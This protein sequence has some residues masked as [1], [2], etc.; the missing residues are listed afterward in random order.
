MKRYLLN[1]MYVPAAIPDVTT[2]ADLVSYLNEVLGCDIPDLSGA[3]LVIGAH[4]V[5]FTLEEIF[6]TFDL[7]TSAISNT[8]N[9]LVKRGFLKSGNFAAFD[10]TSR[11]YYSITKSGYDMANSFFLGTLPGK[12]KY[13]RKENAVSHIYS[14]GMNFFHALMLHIPFYYRKEVILN[15]SLS[16][17]F[18]RSSKG[19]LQADCVITFKS[20]APEVGQLEHTFYVEEDLGFERDSVLHEKLRRYQSLGIM[21]RAGDGILFSFRYKDVSA[22]APS[23]QGFGLYSKKGALYILDLMHNGHVLDA[24]ELTD[25][26]S[27]DD[28]PYLYDFLTMCGAY[29]DGRI[30]KK[31]PAV[32]EEFLQDFIS[33]LSYHRNEYAIRDMNRRQCRLYRSRLSRFVSLYFTWAGENRVLSEMNAYLSGFSVYFAPTCLFSSYLRFLLPAESGLLSSLS[34][35]LLSYYADLGDYMLLSPPLLLDDGHTL[36]FRNCFPYLCGETYSG[37]VCVE[38]LNT[39]LC[40]WIRVL[41][42]LKLYKGDVPFHILC[43]FDT[44]EQVNEFYGYLLCYYGETAIFLDKSLILCTMSYELGREKRFFTMPDP[45]GK[46]AR[47]RFYHSA[48]ALYADL[49]PD[50]PL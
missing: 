18:N 8:I 25:T 17:S 11:K 34:A 7:T 28:A 12:Y 43:V 13:G 4:V 41:Y 15:G 16:S 10:G 24:R 37:F 31:A 29:K 30:N 36:H 23:G 49:Y 5:Y 33:S 44:Q 50:M 20:K 42:F 3:L 32:T 27:K 39:D 38:F 6:T 9:R 35:S 48:C 2:A 45:F 40:A 14:C 21:D 26:L 1:D 22:T 47:D 19:E 46:K